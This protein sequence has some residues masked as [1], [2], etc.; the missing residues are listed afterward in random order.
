MSSALP[1]RRSRT[2]FCI[3]LTACGFTIGLDC[4]YAVMS[5]SIQPGWMTLERMPQSA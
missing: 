2:V 3:T 5:V 1:L 4:I